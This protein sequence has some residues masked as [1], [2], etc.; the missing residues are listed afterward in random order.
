MTNESCGKLFTAGELARMAGVSTRT[1]RFYDSKG[2]LK[3]V[4]HSDSGYRYYD[5]GSVQQLQ[6]ILMLK[7]AGFSLEQTERI[8]RS[9][10][11]SVKLSF[12]AQKKLLTEKKEHIEA[13]ISA[14]EE[15]DE[16]QEAE[17]EELWRRL[18]ELMRFTSQKEKMLVQYAD[19]SNLQRRINIHAYSTAEVPWM[20][21]VFDRMNIRGGMRILELGCGNALLWRENISRIPDG[22]SLE[23]TDYSQGMADSAENLMREFGPELTRRGISIKFGQA[24][25][26]DLQLGGEYDLIIANHMLYHVRERRQLFDKVR[27]L[28]ADGG[29]FCCTTVGER[30]MYELNSLLK[31]FS[32]EI[33][34]PFFDIPGEFSLENGREALSQ[35]FSSVTMEEHGDDLTVDD[36]Q[37]LYYYLYSYPGNVKEILDKRGN[38]LMA[39]LEDRIRKEGAMFITKSQGIFICE[40]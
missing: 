34:T 7:F 31:E 6:K 37:V 8:M 3:P 9:D 33:R 20:E 14:L 39:L 4:T 40:K 23:L 22:V 17:G 29:R 27:G 38:E 28:L 5:E 16:V 12:A 24:D 11:D 32:G 2:I 18:S 26:N 36:P 15:I 35:A 10:N 25:A 21:W 30:H 19:D 1:I 13:I